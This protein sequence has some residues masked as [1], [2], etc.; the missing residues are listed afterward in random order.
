MLG[1]EASRVY[2]PEEEEEE[3]HR[4]RETTQ[5]AGGALY[6]RAGHL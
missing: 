2:T 5:E 3:G 1:G 6:S 4:T